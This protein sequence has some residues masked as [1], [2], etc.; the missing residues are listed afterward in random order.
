MKKI[1]SIKQKQNNALQVALDL[2]LQRL[3]NYD[4][5]FNGNFLEYLEKINEEFEIV[6]SQLNEIS[7]KNDASIRSLSSRI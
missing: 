4:A 1:L 2:K 3:Q 5:F 6:L 7:L